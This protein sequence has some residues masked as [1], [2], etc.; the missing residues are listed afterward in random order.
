MANGITAKQKLDDTI[1]EIRN[2]AHNLY[3]ENIYEIGLVESLREEVRNL[4]S[5]NK[6]FILNLN[7]LDSTIPYLYQI[8]IYRNVVAVPFKTDIGIVFLHPFIKS[9]MKK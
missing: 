5:T 4:E 7:I 3:S 2:V 1:S 6:H 9:K 8:N